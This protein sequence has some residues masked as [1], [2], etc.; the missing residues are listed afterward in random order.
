MNY[1]TT[2]T[3]TIAL[4]V[5]AIANIF[6]VEINESELTQ[7]IEALFVIGAA[8]WVLRERVKKGGISALGFRR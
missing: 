8:L 7:T 3:A 2:Y 5:I 1:S 6:D 4:V